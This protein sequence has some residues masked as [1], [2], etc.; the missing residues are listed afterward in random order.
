M[1]A[2]GTSC[3]LR[4]LRRGGR[5]ALFNKWF[6]FFV[7]HLYGGGGPRLVAVGKECLSIGCREIENYLARAIEQIDMG[8]AGKRPRID[9]GEVRKRPKASERD[10]DFLAPRAGLA[11]AQRNAALRV[12]AFDR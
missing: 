2:A 11:H 5:A 4:Q 7:A 9:R 8:I 10:R 12:C 1:V 3:L 6:L